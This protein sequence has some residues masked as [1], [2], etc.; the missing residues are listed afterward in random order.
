[1][2][3]SDNGQLLSPGFQSAYWGSIN[4]N[5]VRFLNAFESREPWTYKYEE[6][7]ELF[8][9][10]SKML[11]EF[12]ASPIRSCDSDSARSI[13]R[14]LICVLAS[15]PMRQ[16]VSAIA[17]LD[18]HIASDADLGWAVAIYL[19]S[20][21]ITQSGPQDPSYPEAR[22]LHDRINLMLR[23][24]LSTLLFVKLTHIG[25]DAK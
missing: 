6:F 12:S 2:K 8:I 20:A 3:A 21:R 24:R 14:Q 16:A 18:Q 7:P 13:L 1:M 4:P 15:I 22:L 19:E 23:T 5:I 11:P 10:L 25:E 17:W 9:E